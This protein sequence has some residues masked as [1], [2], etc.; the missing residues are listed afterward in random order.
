MPR[1]GG[2]ASDGCFPGSYVLGGETASAGCS[3]LCFGLVVCCVPLRGT[4]EEVCWGA[5][6]TGCS[7]EGGKVCKRCCTTKGETASAG[8]SPQAFRVGTASTGYSTQSCGPAWGAVPMGEEQPVLVVH[9][10]PS[11]LEQPTL[12]VHPVTG[13][14]VGGAVH[15]CEGQSALAVP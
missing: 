5:E 4:L 13:G 12:A 1:G 8:C 14:H 3:P 10:W 7:L 9:L 15:L 6:G 2:T 11:G